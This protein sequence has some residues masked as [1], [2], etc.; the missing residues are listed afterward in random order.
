MAK[1]YICPFCERV[2]SAADYLKH[3]ECKGKNRTELAKLRKEKP[4]LCLLCR[5]APPSSRKT[6]RFKDAAALAKHQT[7]KG[8]TC[9][10]KGAPSLSTAVSS[11][12]LSSSSS[13]SSAAGPAAKNQKPAVAAAAQ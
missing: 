6:Y 7:R 9:Y 1:T 11:K 5:R 12:T 10:V 2:F 3:K 4:V 13:S 8:T